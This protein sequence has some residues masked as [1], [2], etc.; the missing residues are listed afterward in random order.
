[1][2][3]LIQTKLSK[4]E[5]QSIETKISSDELRI[6]QLIHH[7]YESVNIKENHTQNM[8]RFTK[9]DINV[10]MQHHIYNKYF[11]LLVNE[12]KD[13]YCKS[14][15]WKKVKTM[16]SK[17][18]KLKKLKSIDA[19]RIQNVDNMIANEKPKI[20]EFI[21]LDFTRQMCR[22]IKKEAG[23]YPF[24]YYTLN[25]CIQ[26]CKSGAIPNTNPHVLEFIETTLDDVACTIK[27]EYILSLTSSIFEKNKWLHQFQDIQLFNHK[28]ELFTMC[29]THTNE[30]K[31]ILYIAPTGTGKTLSPIGL[32]NGSRIIFVCVARHVGLAL[33]KSAINVDK[34]V[35]FAFGCETASD[36]RLHYFAA[37]DYEVS[38]KSGKIC[39]V[40]N[41]NGSKVEIMICDI[42]SYLVAMY[43]MLAFNEAQDVIT[44]WDE[45]T[46]TMDYEAH[47][48]HDK[49]H[50]NWSKNKIP[51]VILSCAT[52]PKE[53]EIQDVLQDFRIKFDGAI[54]H[55]IV[56]NEYKKTIPII[57]SNSFAFVPHTHYDDFVK[58]REVAQYCTENKTLLR[59]FD[60]EEA[61]YFIKAVHFIHAKL[62]SSDE[63]IIPDRYLL[64][65]YFLDV[66][67]MS[68][69]TL[70]EYYLILL[71]HIAE[72]YWPQ[73]KEICKR[74]KKEKYLTIDANT[75][76]N[77]GQL[78]RTQSVHH[79][80]SVVSAAAA[81]GEEL[82]RN[83]SDSVLQN[84]NICE[85]DT[86][87]GCRLT[88]IDAHTLTD[89]PTIYLV[90]NVSNVAKFC[91]YQSNIPSALMES[92]LRS[93][94]RNSGLQEQIKQ[95][96][97]ELE[98]QLETKSN[99]DAK[100]DNSSKGKKKEKEKDVFTNDFA[101]G[102]QQ[103]I[104]Q[105]QNQ[106]VPVT[107]PHEFIPNSV[108]HQ[109]KWTVNNNQIPDAFGVYI[110]S[111]T[112]KEVMSLD[113]D[114][115]YKFLVMMGIGVLEKNKD[116][117]YEE[118][119]K[120]LAQEQ[121]LY[122]IITSSDYIYGTNYQFCHGFIGKDLQNMTQQ[123]LIQSMGRIGRNNIQQ[124]FSVRF[125]DNAMIDKLFRRPER[126]IEAENMVKL[127]CTDNDD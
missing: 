53:H 34:K 68:M 92:L 93:I 102:L 42:Q 103:N 4:S 49:I 30:P 27:P 31:L 79:T 29:K 116:K 125:R 118:L 85:K 54:I 87:K 3:T 111:T 88:T 99:E 75:L 94:E 97:I 104:R 14:K 15:M 47:D 113:V 16:D 66:M 40:D 80:P 8:V 64:S 57:D 2:D 127:F 122:L 119:V 77:V 19:L 18:T 62:T 41:S 83:A 20:L 89:G 112:V 55:S 115:D 50:T 108:Q 32:C 13:K 25:H 67:Q 81:A 58:I 78:R 28:K 37:V 98:K 7:G 69:S 33:A 109:E 60:L 72:I 74:Y 123:K 51:N 59:Y 6:L 17:A 52:L 84:A 73:V 101:D 43:Y 1:M 48:L 100:N 71:N 70:K 61:M 38:K 95:M 91:I 56:S 96:E 39:K 21:L 35:A 126:N 22:D 86:L 124:T 76:G 23:K 63:P 12:I 10:D 82:R 107:L 105:L 114:N 46:I 36:I 121:K 65:N 110:D 106:I 11:Q 24:Y 120:R 26:S 9:L 5:W 45:P 44:Y 117:K 90:E